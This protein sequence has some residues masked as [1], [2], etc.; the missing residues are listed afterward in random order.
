MKPVSEV[1]DLAAFSHKYSI[2]M[3][4]LHD[5]MPSVSPPELQLQSQIEQPKKPLQVRAREGLTCSKAFV[6]LDVKPQSDL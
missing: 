6:F 2:H 1:A 4:F 5:K 3:S